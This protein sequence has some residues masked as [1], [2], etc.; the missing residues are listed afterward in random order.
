MATFM[1]LRGRPLT[2]NEIR[3]LPPQTRVIPNGHP[4]IASLELSQEQLSHKEL[5]RISVRLARSIPDAEILF[6][7]ADSDQPSRPPTRPQAAP[8]VEVVGGGGWG[9]QSPVID[10]PSFRAPLPPEMP[11]NDGS[12]PE[13]TSVP[14]WWEDVEAGDHDSALA[15]L[16]DHQMSNIDNLNV[17]R[18]LSSNWPEHKIFICYAARRF[19]WKSQ[20][21]RLRFLLNSQNPDIRAA[22]LMTIGELAGPA[23]SSTV[24]A[25]FE[26]PDPQ[27][28]KAAAAAH[29]LLNR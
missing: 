12:T 13:S 1:L 8:D 3:R 28:R 24:R 10:V 29:G 27:V 5:V 17:R 19:G 9:Q 20:A 26:D 11:L 15:K 25:F 7:E 14:T 22:A 16:T 23:L 4:V 2:Q 6:K 18:L 21:L